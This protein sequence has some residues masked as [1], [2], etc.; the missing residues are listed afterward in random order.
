MRTESSDLCRAFL[1]A[2]GDDAGA[3][4]TLAGALAG[5]IETT[6]QTWPD[7]AADPLAFAAYLGQ[8][9]P[10]DV[11]AEAALRERAIGD[12]YLAYAC[13]AGDTAATKYVEDRFAALVGLIVQ[14]GITEEHARDAVQRLRM[15]LLAG[16]RPG[17]RTYSGIGSLKAWLRISAMR[18]AIRVQRRERGH[19][20]E[21]LNETLADRAADPALQY[22]RHLYQAEFRTAFE[23]AVALLSVRERNLL[24]QS[25]LYGATVDDLGAIY[26]VHRA[27]AA[28]W[29]AAARE[30]LVETTRQRMIEIL[31]IEPA[32][33]DSIL[34]MIAS[35][36][37]VSIERVLGA[38][39]E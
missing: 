10:S 9:I 5:V 32:D 19:E 39:S 27:T 14:Q 8:R 25:I 33:Y 38:A 2:R 6:L 21:E 7:V 22:Q 13:L 12:V 18:E 1:G 37:V 34:T 36:L 30:R 17:L 20:A 23:E 29:I 11:D 35:Q 26:Q 16:E 28:R 15:Q 24:K 3:A 31:R 4:A